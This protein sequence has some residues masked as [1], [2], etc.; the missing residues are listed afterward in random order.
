MFTKLRLKIVSK[1]TIKETQGV[2]LTK[3]STVKFLFY[4]TTAWTCCFCP[5]SGACYYG[6]TSTSSMPRSSGS[7]SQA[8][9]LESEKEHLTLQVSVLKDQIDAQ[10]D[11]IRDLERALDER[12]ATV[13]MLSNGDLS[14]KVSNHGNHMHSTRRASSRS[15]MDGLCF[16]CCVIFMWVIICLWSSKKMLISSSNCWFWLALCCLY[17]LA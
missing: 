14:L 13:S 6:N 8:D 1:L 12:R 2:I 5:K 4:K 10:A 11:K 7:E 15:R 9:R 17:W 3:W 16:C